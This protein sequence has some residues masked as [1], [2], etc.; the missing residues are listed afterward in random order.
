MH[1]LLQTVVTNQ[2]IKILAEL[3]GLDKSDTSVNPPPQNHDK[4]GS[5]VM[6]SPCHHCDRIDVRSVE[7][8]AM[9]SKCHFVF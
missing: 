8:I 3:N 7:L 4:P 2:N 9:I 5:P 6:P 1:V